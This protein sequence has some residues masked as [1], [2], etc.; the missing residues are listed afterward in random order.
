[1]LIHF[2]TMLKENVPLYPSCLTAEWC[3]S[4]KE[5]RTQAHESGFSA[6]YSRDGR[7]WYFQNSK[8]LISGDF[9]DG[10]M[11]KLKGG[12]MDGQIVV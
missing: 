8:E 12:P 11:I 4:L 3:E 6:Y 1:V 10:L 2:N 7:M 9:C 5:Y